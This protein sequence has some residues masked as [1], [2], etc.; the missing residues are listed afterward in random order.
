MADR[1]D[2]RPQNER[3]VEHYRGLIAS[4]EIPTGTLLPSNKVLA[5]EWKVSPTTIE[6]AMSKLRAEGLVRGIH[7][8]GTEVVGHPVALSSGSQR[9]DRGQQTG[10][11]WGAGERSDSHTGALVAAPGDVARVLGIRPGDQVVRRTRVYRDG[12]GI[13]AHSTSWIPAELAALVPELA[14]KDRLRGGTSL[15][16]IAGATGRR[17]VLRRDKTGARI[18]TEEDLV[19]LELS[20]TTVAAI[21]VLTATFVDRD[22]RVLE[23]GVDLGAP[24]RTREDV[25]D[26]AS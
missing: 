6:K 22:G 9:Q 15:D 1:V 16:L 19:L 17:A 8:I 10:S 18:A 13:V 5:A 23:Y 11:S 14:R 21:L 7:G 20:S 12:H 26:L 25:S 3:V 4:G 2:N 24:G